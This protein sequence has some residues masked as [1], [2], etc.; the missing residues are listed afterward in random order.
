MRSTRPSLAVL[1][2]LALAACSRPQ[3][4]QTPTGDQALEDGIAQVVA[5][6]EQAQELAAEGGAAASPGLWPTDGS[7]RPG[8]D[9]ARVRVPA[10]E[11]PAR[12]ASEPLVTVV[13]F[14]DFQCPFCTR[15]NP[16]LER[17]IRDNPEDVRVVFRH[18]PLP[19][20]QQA[21]PAAEAA[22]EVYRQGGD[23]KFWAYHDLLFQNQRALSP[24]DL[25]R[26]ARSVG[27][28]PAGVRMAL[29]TNVHRD[30]VQRDMAMGRRA[31]VTGTPT[32]F[33]NGRELVGARPYDHFAAIV[34]EE[35]EL[36]RAAMDNGVPRAHLY[37]AVLSAA[38]DE[39]PEE[40]QPARVDRVPSEPDRR[41]PEPPADAVFHVPVGD[42]PTQGRA[43][44]LVTIVEFADVECP[45]CDRVRPTLE[46]LRQRYGNDVR[47]VWKHNPLPFH[48][49]AMPA[50]IALE[51]ARAQGG[52]RA[53]WRLQELL[54]D[55]QQALE[56]DDLLRYGEEAGLD[57]DRLR[58]AL[59]EERHRERIENDVAL[60]RRV[61]ATGTPSFFINGVK[62]TGAQPLERFTERV[63]ERLADARARLREGTPRRRLYASIIDDGI[64]DIDA[65]RR[66]HEDDPLLT[67]PGHAPTRGAQNAPVTIH[68]FS[69][70]ECPFCGRVRPQL[71]RIL[72]EY[73]GR[74][75]L[76][77]RHYPLS[78]H[79]HAEPA[80]E[81][82]VEVHAQGGNEAFWAYHE[83]LFDN[84]QSLERA[85]LERYAQQVGGVDMVR[86]RNA[87]DSHRHRAVINADME[88]AR[89]LG[90][91]G[92]P[93][94]VIGSEVV[95]GA[96]P[97]EV[98]RDAVERQLDAAS[99]AGDED[100]EDDERG[101]EG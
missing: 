73:E 22:M 12:G 94:L 33:I 35:K 50:A 89:A 63:D 83:L 74:V 92:T 87:L 85:D 13:V 46:S 38:S 20:H 26:Y 58:T 57:V 47:L 25:E 91:I 10:A 14:S 79:P 70:F 68:L 52:D 67:V 31:G 62:L 27:A 51:E 65:W 34:S 44:A 17:L 97:F 69:D 23:E 77:W 11:A 16:T 42:S 1:A 5:G 45:F 8:S 55:N 24:P 64:Q 6:G 28:D 98:L 48:T 99:A 59:D 88:A 93:T 29:D 54:F 80:A 71:E 82:A 86:F 61:G 95:Q 37:A 30:R 96:Q 21:L 9:A 4:A 32:V 15:L 84:Q 39:P 78:M 66:E 43:R 56:R 101:S 81:A 18:F 76:V 90:R 49:N 7:D 36:A 75:R 72:E 19:F 41:R 53:F 3:P 100:D 40:E 2:M 60:A